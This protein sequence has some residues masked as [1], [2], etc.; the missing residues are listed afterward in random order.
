M[1]AAKQASFDLDFR[2]GE[3]VVSP[4]I[5]VLLGHSAAEYR[6]T[7]QSPLESIHPEDRARV[8]ASFTEM[9]ENAISRTK[10][11][12]GVRKRMASGSG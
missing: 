8:E 1:R 11:S 2:T 9:L 7:R 3:T 12:I 6:P 10:K 5:A 4:E